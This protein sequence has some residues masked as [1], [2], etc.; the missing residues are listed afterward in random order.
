MSGKGPPQAGDGRGH[1]QACI[2]QHLTQHTPVTFPP[3]TG[4]P[5]APGT[6]AVTLIDPTVR[7][8]FTKS[9]TTAVKYSAFLKPTTGAEVEVPLAV[10]P[11]TGSTTQLFAVVGPDPP[12]LPQGGTYTLQV[13]HGVASVEGRTLMCKQAVAHMRLWPWGR[14]APE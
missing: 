9:D 6:P 4:V 11:V 3:R 8:V 5:A 12:E 14:Q 10:K 2:V 13:G 1:R 7:L